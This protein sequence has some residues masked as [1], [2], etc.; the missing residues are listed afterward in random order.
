M[1]I[2]HSTNAN[3]S[4]NVKV[5]EL[6]CPLSANDAGD[7]AVV[8]IMSDSTSTFQQKAGTVGWTLLQNITISSKTISG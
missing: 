7:L 8:V 6:L 5:S 1:A 4:N 3:L 2:V